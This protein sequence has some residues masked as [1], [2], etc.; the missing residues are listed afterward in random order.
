[1]ARCYRS[2][3]LPHPI[4]MSETPVIPPLLGQRASRMPLVMCVGE[5]TRTE[6]VSRSSRPLGA[7]RR[8]KRRPT[9][10]HVPARG[11]PLCLGGIDS[12]HGTSSDCPRGVDQIC[13]TIW[14]DQS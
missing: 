11:D 9:P 14:P 13:K 5:S 12:D 3:F 2:L 8:H 4:R 10:D 1:M 7:R 6:R